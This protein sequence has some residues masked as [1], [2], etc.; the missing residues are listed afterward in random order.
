MLRS[1]LNP[2]HYDSLAITSCALY[3]LASTCACS[4]TSPR[5]RSAPFAHSHGIFKGFFFVALFNFQGA[6]CCSRFKGSLFIISQLFGFVK[7]LSIL[8]S[9][10]FEKVLFALILPVR[11]VAAVSSATLTL[12][13]VFRRLSSGKPR[14]FKFRRSAQK[15][16]RLSC[17]RNNNLTGIVEAELRD[18]PAAGLPQCLLDAEILT[19]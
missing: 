6:V 13:H 4:L 7:G 12:Y 9:S 19:Q 16:P 8:F 15:L 11:C 3:S 1:P 10:F 5:F 18:P 17:D 2:S 14:F